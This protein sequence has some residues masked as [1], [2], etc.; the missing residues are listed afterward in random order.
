M[1]MG[2]GEPSQTLLDCPLFEGVPQAPEG[3][4][5]YDDDCDDNDADRA[6]N[7]PN[8]APQALMKL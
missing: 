7:L 1:G 3:Y 5:F 8:C 6:P 2:D 4:S